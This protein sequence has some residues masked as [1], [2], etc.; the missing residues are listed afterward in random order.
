MC[1]LYVKTMDL[2][3]LTRFIIIIIICQ[4]RYPLAVGTMATPSANIKVRSG[5]KGKAVII[6]HVY[7]DFLWAMGDKSDP[8]ELK[9]IS[10]DE[11]VDEGEDDDGEGDDSQQQQQEN[12][13]AT[14]ASDDQP[15]VEH[16]QQQPDQS[17]PATD[18]TPSMNYTTAGKHQ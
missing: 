11:Y 7:N 1:V 3:S 2:D 15:S 4:L 9:D 17:K 5:M 6:L 13:P 12:E 10:D 18:D 16:Q 14:A 8:P